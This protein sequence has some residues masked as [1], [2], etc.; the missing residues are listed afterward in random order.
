MRAVP[1]HNIWNLLTATSQAL[2]FSL[3][4]GCVPVRPRAVSWQVG[5]GASPPVAW[6]ILI[7][8]AS[9][10]QYIIGSMNNNPFYLLL[11]NPIFFNYLFT[12]YL[13]NRS[14]WSKTIR[15]RRIKLFII[16]YRVCPRFGSRRSPHLDCPL[17]WIP[18]AEC[19]LPN[20]AR[21]WFPRSLKQFFSS[22]R[23]TRFAAA[24]LCVSSRYKY[25]S[26]NLQSIRPSIYS[27]VA[28]LLT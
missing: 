4:K 21:M 27:S 8:I 5:A 15:T 17:E 13:S 7:V 1:E 9:I 2:C 22:R 25:M 6:D 18:V 28:N 12:F 26:T 19:I 23:Q 11:T 3:I 16:R 24:N 10:A 14:D 20:R